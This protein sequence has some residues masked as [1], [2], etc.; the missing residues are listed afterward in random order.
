MEN[1][2][3][4]QEY[5][6]RNENLPEN[7]YEKI[8][9]LENLHYRNKFFKGFPDVNVIEELASIYKLAVE[10]FCQIDKEKEIYFYE[11]MQNLLSNDKII[12]LIDDNND[13]IS[14]NSKIPS[15][16]TISE[17]K[18]NQKYPLLEN[19][20]KNTNSYKKINTDVK[21]EINNN[22][23][24]NHVDSN[25][26]KE[27]INNS[28]SKK[29]IIT[30]RGSKLDQQ[31]MDNEK[32]KRF[33]LR[34][35]LIMNKLKNNI[36]KYNIQEM[37]DNIS[38]DHNTGISLLNRDMDDQ[39]KT[40]KLNLEKAKKEKKLLI[41]ANS[42]TICYGFENSTL[43]N[44]NGKAILEKKRIHNSNGIV[45]D[46]FSSNNDKLT[47][48]INIQNKKNDKISNEINLTNENN[49]LLNLSF[50]SRRKISINN[51]VAE[52][53]KEFLH[54]YLFKISNSVIKNIVKNCEDI[55]NEKKKYFIKYEEELDIFNDMIYENGVL[56]KS[57]DIDQS[58]KLI[59]QSLIMERNEKL[60]LQDKLLQKIISEIKI[61]GEN[62]DLNNDEE[63]LIIMN[64]LS[65]KIIGIFI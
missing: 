34:F 9:E 39:E 17:D 5:Y 62:L 36:E 7:F 1:I 44:E 18:Y 4:I 37:Q 55:Y 27:T 60:Y 53:L 57:E 21:K 40:F 56:K 14:R 15:K 12:K 46:K 47:D 30:N 38:E 10:H 32:R 33:S 45:D 2:K 22:N 11:K 28:S 54:V 25:I 61:K 58:I 23:Q 65:D 50:L 6:Y 24:E 3:L 49:Q 8:V 42:N 19:E 48:E 13:I 51:I 29:S 26:T 35:R 31:I 63:F 59:M 41:L 43:T 16:D 64:T 52:F 20:N